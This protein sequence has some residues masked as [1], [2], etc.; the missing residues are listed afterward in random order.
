MVRHHT[1]GLVIMAKNITKTARTIVRAK[2][3]SAVARKVA[4]AATPVTIMFGLD[5]K[6]VF[7]LYKDRLT[8]AE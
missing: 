6:R 8:K 5:F 2:A 1:R 7:A 4:P 3:A